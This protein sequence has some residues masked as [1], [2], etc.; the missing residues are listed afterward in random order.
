MF[1]KLKSLFDEMKTAQKD[2]DTLVKESKELRKQNKTLLSKIT[3]AEKR[4]GVLLLSDLNEELIDKLQKLTDDNIVIIFTEGDNTRIE[5]RKQ[6]ANYKRNV[7][8][9][10]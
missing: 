9:I 2:V 3:A 10:F 1:K 7:G 4:G 6:G 8:G 5:I